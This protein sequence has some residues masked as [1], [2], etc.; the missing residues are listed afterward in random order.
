LARG[1]CTTINKYE[2]NEYEVDANYMRSPELSN[3]QQ[4]P[5]INEFDLAAANKPSINEKYN[6]N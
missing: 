3:E 1:R 5:S 4:N 2:L 6:W